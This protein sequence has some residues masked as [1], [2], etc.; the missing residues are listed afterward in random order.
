MNGRTYRKSFW[1]AL[2]LLTS[3]DS[4]AQFVLRDF[5]LSND[6]STVAFPVA[7]T[8]GLFEWRT[9][10]LQTIPLPPRVRSMWAPSFSTD[11]QSLAVAINSDHGNIAILELASLQV[12]DIHR[13]ECWLE[14]RPVLQPGDAALLVV[15][16][17]PNQLCLY[18]RKEQRTS[19]L[20]PGAGTFYGI[21]KP[22]FIDSNTV[23]FVG[24][25]PKDKAL[26]SDVEKI[27]ASRTSGFVP[28]TMRLLDRPRI[29]FPGLVRRNGR[30]TGLQSGGPTSLSSS[31]GGKR[32]VFIGRSLSEE[33]R[34]K[35]ERGGYYRYDLFLIEDETVKQVT[36]LRTYMIGEAISQDG[37][38]AAVGISR[39]LPASAVDKAPGNREV[40]LSIIDLATG[41]IITTGLSARVESLVARAPGN[42]GPPGPP[43]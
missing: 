34:I 21:I 27:G 29:A 15:G 22:N 2:L 1:L 4:H 11:G 9:G 14:S 17:S 7:G 38:T 16:G 24:I 10:R 18:D 31:Q 43:R 26:A 13:S 37:T 35:S 19:I 3:P 33:D 8:V 42:S 23:L 40:D 30:L 6:G 41:N 12:K 36:D 5:V 28:Y 39:K 25:G 20:S 32:I